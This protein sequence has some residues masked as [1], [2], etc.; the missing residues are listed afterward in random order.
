MFKRKKKKTGCETPKLRKPT[1]PPEPL[2]FEEMEPDKSGNWL[3]GMCV[4]KFP[5]RQMT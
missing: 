2:K 3:F 5:I 1:P 4:A